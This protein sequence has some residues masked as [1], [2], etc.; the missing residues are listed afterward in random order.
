[1]MLLSIVVVA[2]LA[3]GAFIASITIPS[4]P[5][6]QPVAL[7]QGGASSSQEQGGG[8]RS[9]AAGSNQGSANGQ[10]SGQTQGQG[11]APLFGSVTSRDGNTFTVSTQQGDRKVNLSGAKLQKTVDGTTDD[12]KAGERVV[13]TGQQGQDGVLAASSIQIRPDGSAG[14]QGTMA[15]QSGQ[16]QG[17]AQGQGQGQDSS[18]GAR[19]VAG[20]ISSVSGD[21]ATVSTQQGD[22]KV[23]L[24]GAKIRKTVEATAD[25]LKAGERVVV[26]GQQGQDGSYTASSV[27]ISPDNGQSGQPPAAR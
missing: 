27:Q 14:G 12:L 24:S 17:Q 7:A 5:A 20:S 19:P 1:M 6:A 23:K 18:Q 16:R 2:G 4:G 15:G 13:V 26:M 25:D 11:T 9:G 21:T 22:V 8:N 10:G 3:L